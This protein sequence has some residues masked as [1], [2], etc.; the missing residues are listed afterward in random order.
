MVLSKIIQ[1]DIPKFRL[2]FLDVPVGPS[3]DV[4]PQIGRL[5]DERHL[6]ALE[7]AGDLVGEVN[8]FLV[9]REKV[10][11][12]LHGERL[13]L[14]VQRGQI[15]RQPGDGLQ[16]LVVLAHLQLD[17]IEQSPELVLRR[18]EIRNRR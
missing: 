11:L 13:N 14:L 5:G 4:V 10:L 1:K 12:G 8:G 15:L 16:L 9:E 3:H 7:V 18:V 6:R 2:D 17:R